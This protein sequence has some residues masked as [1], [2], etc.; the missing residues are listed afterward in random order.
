MRDIGD[1]EFPLDPSQRAAA[2]DAEG[3]TLVG[4]G[5]GTGKS[6]TLVARI[7]VLLEMGVPPDRI[8]CL[9]TGS[10]GAEDMRRRLERHP[11]TREWTGDIFVGSFHQYADRFL[12]TAGAAALGGSAEYTI[13][14]R[15]SAVEALAFAWPELSRVEVRRKELGEVLR[16]HTLNRA[17]WADTPPVPAR[18]SHWWD[19]VTAYGTVKRAQNALDPDDLLDLTIRA[20]EGNPDLRS[21]WSSSR[22]RHLVVDQFEE[23]TPQQFLMLELM[24]GPI[25][26]LMVASD[27]NQGVYGSEGAR[28]RL[29]RALTLRFPG[30]RVHRLRVN[31]QGSRNLGELAVRLTRSAAMSGL[32]DDHQ[33]RNGVEKAKPVLMET[34][35]TRQD[36]DHAVLG[37]VRRLAGRGWSFDDMACLYRR[38]GAAGRMRTKLLHL[39]IPYHVLDEG[40]RE[41]EGDARSVVALLTSLLNPRDLNAVRAAAAPGYPG[42][43]R[44]LNDR[45]TR[46]L[47]RLSREQKVDLIRA[48]EGN[49][50]RFEP[51]SA[52]HRAVSYLIEAWH[53][54]DRKL[55]DPGW[56]LA[57]LVVIAS[58]LMRE[59]RP[60]GPSPA[61]EPEMMALWG[62]CRATPRRE[63]EA[64]RAYLSR[65]LDLL[66][67]ALAS[68]RSPSGSGV[69]LS[70]IQAAKG[71]RWPVVFILDAS[72]QT[73]PGNVGPYSDI[74]EDEQRVFYLGVTRATER[75]YLFSP[76]DGGRAQESRPSRFLEP[77]SDLLE[78]RQLGPLGPGGMRMNSG[79]GLRGH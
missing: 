50:S 38:N 10:G 13:W 28:S 43:A 16:W 70:T 7:A 20:M 24:I 54:L 6:H 29:D 73:M 25:R 23:A 74:L 72:D 31:Q 15:R 19:I 40:R 34:E 17:G 8:T 62:Q 1:Y 68:R 33:V 61:E 5:P 12:R 4:G 69:T 76:S 51:G 46:K 78:Y 49:L 65:F 58:V 42:K 64:S 39:D 57:D 63:G 21:A 71:L 77:V 60:S 53:M 47:W 22:S 48:A 32:E 11:Q 45:A 56:E 75:L 79:A 67:P 27:P 3:V 37:E 44:R 36:M 14:D 30:R 55:E 66:C 2:H 35:G 18:E 59:H 41:R 52:D 9:S 26:S